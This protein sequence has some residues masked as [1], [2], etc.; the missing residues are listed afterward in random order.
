M[1]QTNRR[2]TGRTGLFAENAHDPGRD[3][4]DKVVGLD[5]YILS[6]SAA[7]GKPNRHRH[8]ATVRRADRI[9]VVT[10]AGIAEQ[11]SHAALLQAGGVYRALHEAQFGGRAA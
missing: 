7:P 4:A 6:E 10:E 11:G 9:L 1:W 5:T 2:F 8:L 3:V